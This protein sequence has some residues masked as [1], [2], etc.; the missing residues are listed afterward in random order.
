MTLKSQIRFIIYGGVEGGLT[1][2]WFWKW[3]KFAQGRS[4]I[5]RLQIPSQVTGITAYN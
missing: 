1:K 4:I 5:L 3:D 2:G